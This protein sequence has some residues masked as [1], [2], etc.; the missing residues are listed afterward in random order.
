LSSDAINARQHGASPV[1]SIVALVAMLVFTTVLSQFF[2]SA[3]AVIAP[4]LIADL[5]LNAGT[6]GLAN[7]GFFL[8]LMVAQ[9]A[10]G[11]AF[12]RIGPRITVS[13]LSL[14]MTAGAAMHAA[15][16]SGDLLVAA[17]FVT[18]LG[19]AGSFMSSIVL[20]SRW[21]SRENWGLV[22]SGVNATSQ[23]GILLAG[24]PLALV[25]TAYGWRTAFAISAV[26]SGLCG[27][28][29]YV[30][31]R[32]RPAGYVEP[33][34]AQQAPPLGVWA[35]LRAVVATPGALQTFALFSVAY[36]S[37]V[38]FT[39]LWAGPYLRDVHGLDTVA[40]G[41]V[42]AA[43]ATAQTVAILGYGV[44]DRVIQSRRRVIIFGAVLTLVLLAALAIV[45]TPPLW[46]AVSLLIVM[47]LVSGYGTVLLVHVRSHFPDHLAGRGATTGNMAQLAGTASLPYIT[48]LV[49]DAFVSGGGAAYPP[50]AYAA[51]F[52]T[53]AVALALGLIVFLPS[54]K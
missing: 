45:P 34:A 24:P 3:L 52:A 46:L 42:L 54:R 41:N 27:V 12:D 14:F 20:V 1:T 19:C 47:G 51:I 13:V 39:G 26:L 29:F 22:A 40:R 5:G 15:A 32:D 23:I 28:L 21:F 16:V 36:A 37:T 38:T 49:L 7:G 35:G 9:V 44:L 50:E 43:I 33:P 11:Y 48:G 18:G 2:R 6:L 17:R 30:L 25:A 31:V 10:V 53:L 4:E 8:A